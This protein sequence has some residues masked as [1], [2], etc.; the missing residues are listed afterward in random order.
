MNP[1]VAAYY[2]NRSFAYM[3]TEAYGYALADAEK[4][5]ELEPTYIK[6]FARSL[7]LL[8]FL[9]KL[10]VYKNFEIRFFACFF[11]NLLGLLQES[12]REYGIMQV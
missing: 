5:I 7:L 4:A 9:K 12:S 3:K 8:F 2:A 11:F 1:N 10:T 6:V